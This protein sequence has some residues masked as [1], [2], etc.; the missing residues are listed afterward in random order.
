ML[1]EFKTIIME[2]KHRKKAKYLTAEA[3]WLVRRSHAMQNVGFAWRGALV[4]FPVGNRGKESLPRSTTP[5]RRAGHRSLGSR[6]P[7]KTGSRAA[8]R[9]PDSVAR[10]GAR[11]LAFLMRSRRC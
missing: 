6:V 1:M 10:V 11:E 3:N 7:R 9:D 8:L 4:A 5:S 2:W